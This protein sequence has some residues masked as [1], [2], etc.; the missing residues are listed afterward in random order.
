MKNLLYFVCFL[1]VLYLIL[2][3]RQLRSYQ[4]R[5]TSGYHSIAQESITKAVDAN[6]AKNPYLALVLVRESISELKTLSRVVGGREMAL[7][8]VGVDLDQVLDTL[9]HQEK[10]TRHAVGQGSGHYKE[11][12][13]ERLMVAAV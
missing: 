4:S 11:H 3:N 8:L 12:P 7:R 13:L 9:S 6:N 2:N 5:R 1:I 10:K